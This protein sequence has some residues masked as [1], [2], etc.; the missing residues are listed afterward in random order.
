MRSRA[1]SFVEL[2]IAVSVLALLSTVVAVNYSGAR[3]NTRDTAL[4]SDARS[5][6][7]AMIA[8]QQAEGT[9]FVTLK[10]KPCVVS[11]PLHGLVPATGTGCVGMD[12]F[13]SGRVNGSSTRFGNVA[14][15]DT[16]LG[17]TYTPVSIV[18]ALKTDGYLRSDIVHPRSTNLNSTL[19]P[20]YFVVLAGKDY[21]QSIH[22]KSAGIITVAYEQENP[23]TLEQ[24]QRSASYFGAF[25]TP[26]GPV[27]FNARSNE[28]NKNVVLI[29][30]EPV[31]GM[32]DL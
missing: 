2:T 7:A 20:D 4:G 19:S 21:N 23:T 18:D 25:D 28:L 5:L 30:S 29:G 9:A 27:E 8:R 6:L 13:S 22:P 31:K 12:G 14:V 1:F 3:R 32:C 16:G 24:N 11:D 15:G 17:R 26:N 10:G